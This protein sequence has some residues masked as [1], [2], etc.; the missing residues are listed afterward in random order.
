MTSFSTSASS[1]TIEFEEGDMDKY[2]QQLQLYTFTQEQGFDLLIRNYKGI[3]ENI[4]ER[5]WTKFCL[6]AEEPLIISVV[7]EFYLAF[8]KKGS[9]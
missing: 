7:Q 1:P 9:S 2:L 3:W 5:E 4:T 6:L 8:K